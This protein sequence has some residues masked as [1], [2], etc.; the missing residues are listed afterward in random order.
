MHSIHIHNSSY[1][2]LS[3]NFNRCNEDG[4]VY[5]MMN[6]CT[7]P[8]IETLPSNCIPNIDDRLRQ[9]TGVWGSIVC[10]VGTSGNLLN[11][12]AVSFAALRKM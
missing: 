9:F 7:Q 2:F 8:G 4:D 3:N 1:S 10:I 5:E 11:L 6:I 12:C